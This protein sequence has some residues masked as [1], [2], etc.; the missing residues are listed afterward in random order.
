GCQPRTGYSGDR[1]GALFTSSWGGCERARRNDVAPDRGY[2]ENQAA[3]RASCSVRVE[4]RGGARRILRSPCL[5]VLADH[6]QVLLRHRPRSI[7]ASRQAGSITTRRLLRFGGWPSPTRGARS[8]GRP[9]ARPS[10]L[11]TTDRRARVIETSF[12]A[13]MASFVVPLP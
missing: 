4:E 6:L 12:G 2:S 9:A 3:S 5:D 13:L 7:S 8:A 11:C 10:W 1:L